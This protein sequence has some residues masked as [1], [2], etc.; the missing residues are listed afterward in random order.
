MVQF[1]WR[2]AEQREYTH[3]T[4]PSF[5]TL[6]TRSYLTVKG[7]AEKKTADSSFKNAADLLMKIAQ[8]ISEGPSAGI[9]IQNYRSY[10]PYPVQAVWSGSDNFDQRNDFKLWLKQP[11]FVKEQ[12]AKTA[13]DLLG[14]SDQAADVQFENLAEGTEIQIYSA[15]PLTVDRSAFELLKGQISDNHL[16]RLDDTSHREVYVDGDTQTDGVILRLAIDP[17]RGQIDQNKLA[18]N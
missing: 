3:E 7:H 8:K 16:V 12:Y 18:F 11:L 1:D 4:T 2:E 5:V 17:D 14:L 15:K 10:H 6:T 9:E 13:I